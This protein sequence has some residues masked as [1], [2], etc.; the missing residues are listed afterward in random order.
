MTTP[1]TGPALTGAGP[2]A[3]RGPTGRVRKLPTGFLRGAATAAFQT[4]G[5]THEDGR[6]TSI[7]WPADLD[8]MAG[9]GIGAYR[10]STAWPKRSA[11]VY[12]DV[13]R[14]GSLPGS[15]TVCP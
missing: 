15:D 6:T 8:L 3:G 14:S 11:L 1:V 9:L 7:R 10:F 2:G 12:G 13:A 5:A 4:E